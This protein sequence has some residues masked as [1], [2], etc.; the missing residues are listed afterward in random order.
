MDSFRINPSQNIDK[1]QQPQPPRQDRAQNASSFADALNRA[2]TNVLQPAI[3]FSKHAAA[4]VNS[5]EVDL[6]PEQMK[7]VET[8]ITAARDKGVNDSLVL[9]DG[10]ALVV[11][12]K[13]MTVVTAMPNG[14]N[15]GIFTNINGA[16]IV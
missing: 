12:T 9:V 4:R 7:R 11:N 10:Y 1:L 6:S 3:K 15:G 2:N 13:S 5:R 14:A 16:V 8:G